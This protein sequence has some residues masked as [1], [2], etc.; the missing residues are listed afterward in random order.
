MN[1]FWKNKNIFITGIN[2]F[3]GGNVGK[4]LIK[5][6]A[7][8]F[9]LVRD[10][11][12]KTFI[13]YEDLV[14]E[15][16]LIHGDLNDRTL[17]SR[18]INEYNID[19]IFH[20]AAQVEVGIGLSNPFYTFESNIR[21]T[22]SL[23]DAIRASK[24]KVKSIVIASSDKAYGS[25]PRKSMPY[26]EHYPL[27]PEYPYDVSKACADMIAKTYSNEPFNMP[28]VITR[29]CNIY[30]PGQLN[31]TAIIPD[32]IRS[33][34]KYSKF[35]PRGNGS[36]I[37]DFIYVDDV[38]QLYLKLSEKIIKDPLKFKGQVFNAGTNKGYS[39]KDTL[40]LIYNLCDNSKDY[41]SV[42]KRMKKKKTTGEI[43]LQIMDYQ[44]INKFIG[45]KPQYS[46]EKGL[47]ETIKWFDDYLEKVSND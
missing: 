23:L 31:F 37:R 35:I 10:N 28:I 11:K 42:L 3:I 44:K 29:F 39:V 33:A 1:K 34:L 5:S 6:G 17:I 38:A 14:K 45:W 9:G 7:N 47:T 13:Y 21:G 8:V 2:G 20:F 15:L 43:G 16:T 18:I 25:Y 24:T 30:G 12:E 19:A 4:K 41:N 32:G 46:F 22:Y 36:Q 26:K 40:S 27:M